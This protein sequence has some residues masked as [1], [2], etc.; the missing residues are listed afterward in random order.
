[1]TTLNII[2]GGKVGKTLGFL[3]THQANIKLNT[4]LCRSHE[5][6]LL[7]QQFLGSGKPISHFK[8]LT[9][10]DIYLI[11][12]PDDQISTIVTALN[13]SKLLSTGNLVFHCSGTL[14][15]ELLQPLQAHG[16]LV[17][18][19]HP[20]KSFGNPK[21]NVTSF[22]ET[23]CT[24]EGD[25]KACELLRAIFTPIVSKIH[26]ISPENKLLYHAAFVFSCNYFVGLVDVSLHLLEKSGIPRTLAFEMLEPLIQGSLHQIKTLD[27]PHALTGPISRGDSK[28]IKMQLDS[29]NYEDEL[30]GDLYKLLGK[31]TLD[32]AKKRQALS[33][34]ETLELEK[35]LL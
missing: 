3:L 7:A 25:R 15:S 18:S 23:V 16:A 34:V 14:S 30:L 21:E 35:I 24:I 4:I 9:P 5:T 17:A 20:I 27:T 11:A 19:L 31:F 29:L 2:G 6:S 1:M 13:E 33:E 8:E 22:K 32:V 12:V 26:S 10:A 28:L